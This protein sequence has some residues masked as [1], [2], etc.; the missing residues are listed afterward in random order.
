MCVCES[1]ARYAEAILIYVLVHARKTINN[2]SYLRHHDCSIRT[3]VVWLFK[4]T[5]TV[6]SCPRVR[7]TYD[8][9][10]KSYS[11]IQL[12][13][14]IMCGNTYRLYGNYNKCFERSLDYEE[15]SVT[16]YFRCLFHQLQSLKVALLY[17]SPFSSSLFRCVISH[18]FTSHLC[19]LIL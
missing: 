17:E 16:L 8:Q 3:D 6:C 2:L 9:R 5:K 11:I 14:H 7:S 4:A 19:R 12:I 18:T 13:I 15:K 1:R 10:R